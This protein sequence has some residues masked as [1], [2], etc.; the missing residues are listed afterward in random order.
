MMAVNV[1]RDL[2]RHDALEDAD[3]T[4][5]QFTKLCLPIAGREGTLDHWTNFGGHHRIDLLVQAF[6]VVKVAED[7]AQSHAGACG[8]G[9]RTGRN[10]ARPDEFQHRAYDTFAAC[11]AALAPA[12]GLFACGCVYI[13]CPASAMA[14]ISVRESW[15]V[16]RAVRQDS[17]H[18][19]GPHRCVA[20]RGSRRISC[21]ARREIWRDTSAASGST[22]CPPARR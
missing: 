15:K 18:D 1:R 4:V 3:A 11:F 14:G 7:R 9:F 8:D 10:L 22:C 12:I 21:A 16:S 20:C 6:H 5:D 17:L 2:E 13:H 19:R